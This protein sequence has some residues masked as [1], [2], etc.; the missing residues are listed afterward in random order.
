MGMGFEGMPPDS[1]ANPDQ[2]ADIQLIQSILEPFANAL[3]FLAETVQSHD[4]R[5]GKLDEAVFDNIIGGIMG[6]KE[7]Q[8]RMAGVTGLQDKYGPAIADYLP[9]FKQ[10]FGQD[11][12]FD[13][14]YDDMQGAKGSEGFD[15]SGFVGDR[16]Q[17]IKDHLDGIRKSFG[18]GADMNAKI[19]AVVPD[20]RREPTYTIDE[21]AIKDMAAKRRQRG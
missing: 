8:D 14:I 3:Q 17:A 12:P 10:T 9:A 16:L 2:D 4:E 15:E 5:L 19:E 1:G 20:G 11:H 18:P 13:G 7:K 6:L 21:Q